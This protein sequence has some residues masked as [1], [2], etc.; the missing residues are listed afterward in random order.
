MNPIQ[1]NIDTSF[2]E[3]LEDSIELISPSRIRSESEEPILETSRTVTNTTQ[4]DIVIHKTTYTEY[5]LKF[6]LHICI[7]I[8]LLSLLEPIL[9]FNYIVVIEKQV[10]FNQLK[11]FL[12]NIEP[13][14]KNN[15]QEIRNADFYNPMIEFFKYEQL[16]NSKYFDDLEQQAQADQ[17]IINDDNENLENIS[18]RFF[19]ILFAC[20]CL[21]YIAFQYLY[22]RKY[23]IFKILLK[24]LGLILFIGVYEI[25]FF[26]NVVIK[27]VPWS[28]SQITYY[29]MKC[30]AYDFL[31]Y[32]P[33]FKF[34]FEN[35]ELTC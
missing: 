13:I 23:F 34:S 28:E 11:K 10:F 33:E 22:K 4:T 3:V 32:Y 29:I 21:Y 15:N 5:T 9:Y 6:I 2:N 8:T 35:T 19:Y 31:K 26:Q 12:K 30:A 16:D 18:F 1:Y 25:W 14:I 20:T 7:H 17:I 24:H 27:Y